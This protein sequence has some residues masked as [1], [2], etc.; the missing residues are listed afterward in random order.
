MRCNDKK[1]AWAQLKSL[2]DRC[3]V[4]NCFFAEGR[5]RDRMATLFLLLLRR[6][7]C[8]KR[9]CWGRDA[10]TLLVWAS[11]SVEHLV[12]S[13]RIWPWEPFSWWQSLNP[14]NNFLILPKS[15]FQAVRAPKKCHTHRSKKVHE[16]HCAKHVTKE[17]RCKLKALETC[18]TLDVFLSSRYWSERFFLLSACFL[19]TTHD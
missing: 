6:L 12:S 16:S 4:A 7:L 14:C 1:V 5:V 9:L 10:E 8:V 2:H 17:Y 13:Q 11:F 18:F 19:C 3:Q 15:V